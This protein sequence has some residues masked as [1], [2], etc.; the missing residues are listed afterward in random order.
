MDVLIN[1]APSTRHLV[2]L[3]AATRVADVLPALH[4]PRVRPYRSRTTEGVF[5]NGLDEHLRETQIR[6]IS[7]ERVR[8]TEF[9]LAITAIREDHL[10]R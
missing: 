2:S 3:T 9:D 10:H 5:V 8:K 4:D 7:R 6:H 1:P